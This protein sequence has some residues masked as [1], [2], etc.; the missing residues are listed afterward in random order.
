MVEDG[1]GICEV[2][3]RVL[4]LVIRKKKACKGRCVRV[5]VHVTPHGFYPNLVTCCEMNNGLT[6]PVVVLGVNVGSTYFPVVGFHVKTGPVRR[7]IR[8]RVEVKDVDA[9]DR[10]R[11]VRGGR[12]EG[13]P[14]VVQDVVH[15]DMGWRVQGLACR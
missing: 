1:R 12:V 11:E 3:S 5:V 8:L 7:G 13:V 15:L 2:F 10:G 14:L 9:S 4:L 6:R